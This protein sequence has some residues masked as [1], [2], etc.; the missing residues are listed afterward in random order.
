[1]SFTGLKPYFKTRLDS[2]NSGALKEWADAFNVDNIPATAL[3]KAYHIEIQPAS[4][5]GSAHGCL[6]FSASV[7]V[8]AF[9]KGHARPALAIDKA[10]EYVDS[11][12]KE[13]C[14]ST[15]RL[16]EPKVKNILPNSVDIKALEQSNDNV[17]VLDIVFSC[18]VYLD[19]DN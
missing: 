15:N 3:D 12:I 18:T 11:I 16:N 9:F 2:I 10:A 6:G 5:V 17:A 7:R 4:Y 14:K 1:M 19:P 13:C 8:R